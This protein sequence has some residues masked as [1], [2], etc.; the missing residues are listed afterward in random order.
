MTIDNLTFKEMKEV[1]TFF[2]SNNQPKNSNDN[3]YE[4]GE[5]YLIRTVTMMLVGKLEAVYQSELVLS[6]PSW[7]ASSGRFNEALKDG[8]ESL[9]GSEI[10]PFVNNV[11]VGRGALVDAT[12]YNFPLPTKVK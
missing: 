6:T 9:S 3:P 7:V 11:I 1:A 12:I 4:I 10:E 2:G 8:L 5:N